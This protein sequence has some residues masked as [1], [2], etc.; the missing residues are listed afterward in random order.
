MTSRNWAMFQSFPYKHFL[1]F[2]FFLHLRNDIFD[3]NI[4]CVKSSDNQPRKLDKQLQWSGILTY[5][6][7]IIL[8]I[9][10]Q[11]RKKTI[12]NLLNSSEV[13]KKLEITSGVSNMGITALC[14]GL[15]SVQV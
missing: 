15:Q 4:L 11:L 12:A 5:V 1:I 7:Y 9:S 3:Q 10:C 13:S 8:I 2:F 14:L 6:W